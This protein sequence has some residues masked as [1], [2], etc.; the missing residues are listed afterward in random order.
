[1]SLIKTTSQLVD[2]VKKSVPAYSTF[3]GR[4]IHPATRFFQALRIAVNSE[5]DNLEVFMKKVIH[6]IKNKGRIVVISYHSLEDRIVKL[7]MKSWIGGRV[8]TNKV[9]LPGED[10]IRE[11]PSSRSAKLRAFEFG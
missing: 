7:A 2:I 6:F 4:R 1:M 9:M 10:E 11:N 3:R 8:L 5:L